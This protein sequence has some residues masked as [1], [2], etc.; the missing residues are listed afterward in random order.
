MSI[1]VW[2]GKGLENA[3]LRR[4]QCKISINS[5]DEGDWLAVFYDDLWWLA[6]GMDA[7]MKLIHEKSVDLQHVLFIITSMTVVLS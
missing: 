2:G 3:G 5:T 6:K 4:T 1:I 7:L